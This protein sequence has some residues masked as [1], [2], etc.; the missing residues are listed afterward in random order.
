M[1]ILWNF[2]KY[3]KIEELPFDPLCI[4]AENLID[5]GNGVF[6]LPA[7]CPVAVLFGLA[8]THVTNPAQYNAIVSEDCFF[9]A[10][11]A[12]QS[13]VI[14]VVRKGYVDAAKA[15]AAFNETLPTPEWRMTEEHFIEIFSPSLSAAGVYLVPS[16]GQIGGSGGGSGGLLVVQISSS[17]GQSV[18]DKTWQEIADSD[19]AVCYSGSKRFMYITRVSSSELGYEV[20]VVAWDGSSGTFVPNVFIAASTDGYPSLRHA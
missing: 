19:F 4:N 8:T 13:K 17:G 9:Y 5:R 18:M 2:D 14:P 15:V 7:G 16:S 12:N 6:L 1:S 20:T 10:Q 11:Q 3:A